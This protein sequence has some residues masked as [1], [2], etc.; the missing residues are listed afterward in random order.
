[1]RKI[2][3]ITGCLVF[4][5]SHV[6]AQ[7]ERGFVRGLGGITFGTETS[8]IVGGGA[9]FNVVPNLQ[10]TV[11]IGRMQNVMPRKIK[12]DLDA[13]ATLITIFYGVP[14]TIDVKIPAFYAA[15]G[16]RYNVPT[17]GRLRPFINGDV[18]VG[19]ISADITSTVAGIDISRDVEEAADL[20]TANK[21]LLGLGGGATLGLTDA[22]GLDIGY[23][24]NRIFTDD[25][26]INASAL[27]AAIRLSIK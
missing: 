12:D 8:S 6:F 27:Y 7:A 23:R 21:F 10:V 18:G 16:L 2:V 15:G 11:D 26:A 19:H 9:G 3:A 14:V 5:A 17:T 1:M 25:P 4:F 22:V 13:A 20:G 24:F